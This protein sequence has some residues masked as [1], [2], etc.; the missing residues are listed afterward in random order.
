MKKIL[1]C[2]KHEGHCPEVNFHEDGKVTIGE[3]KN[4]ATLTKEQWNILVKT[5][6]AGKI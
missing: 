4:I 3:K 6:K 5:V 1:L 2:E